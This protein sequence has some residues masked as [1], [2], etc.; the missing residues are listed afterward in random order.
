MWKVMRLQSWQVMRTRLLS[1]VAQKE[2]IIP[3]KR[4]T[5]LLPSTG[6]PLRSFLDVQKVEN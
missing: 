5:S 1:D 4:M 2:V 6:T 3:I